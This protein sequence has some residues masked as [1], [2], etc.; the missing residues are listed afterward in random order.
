MSA[1]GS[2]SCKA[3]SMCSK[4]VVSKVHERVSALLQPECVLTVGQ[5]EQSTS[6]T[7]AAIKYNPRHNVMLL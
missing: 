6:L 1:Q 2:E 5:R 3:S 7:T 4:H